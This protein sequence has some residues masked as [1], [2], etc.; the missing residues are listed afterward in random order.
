MNNIALGRDIVN[1]RGKGNV[2]FL[3]EKTKQQTCMVNTEIFIFIY[4]LNLFIELF[5]VFNIN[6]Y[7]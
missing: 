5:L 2:F 3:K 6:N 7:L 1:A 4:T